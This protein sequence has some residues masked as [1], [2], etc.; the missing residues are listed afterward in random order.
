MFRLTLLSVAL[1]M[2]FCCKS[3]EKRQILSKKHH[4]QGKKGL[5]AAGNMGSSDA[6]AE[7]LR[8]G[9]NA[10]DAA[11]ATILALSITDN[12]DFCIGS[13]AAFLYYDAKSGQVTAF[14]GQGTAPLDPEAIR[15]Y[16]EHGI[17][18]SS[19]RAAAVPAVIDL[20]V[21][22][23]RKC[24]TL[25]FREV[26]RPAMRMLGGKEQDWYPD[27]LRTFRRLE[28]SERKAR[29]SRE[30]KL[31]AV[32]DCFYRGE[33]ADSLVAWYKRTGAFLTREDLA[34][35]HTRVEK[36]VS[37]PFAGYEVYKCGP[38][39]QG[40]VLLEELR[41]L[42]G[43]DLSMFDPGSA[44]YVHLVTEAMKLGLADR[45]TYYGDPLFA[46]VP[47]KNLISES[48]S[49]LRRPL[50]SMEE[51][52]A[53][54]RPGDPFK[55]KALADTAYYLPVSHGTTTCCI[56]DKWG[57]AVAATPS[58]WGSEAGNGGSTGVKHG[59]RLIS[60]NTTPGHPNAIEAGKRPRT[61]LTPTLVLKNGKPVLALSIEGGDVQDQAALQL[62]LDVLIYGMSPEQALAGPRFSTNLHQDS[63]N[64]DKDRDKAYP[65]RANSFPESRLFKGNARFTGEN[66][67]RDRN[68]PGQRRNTGHDKIRSGHRHGLF[69][70]SARAAPLHKGC[71]IT[72]PCVQTMKNNP[73][74]SDLK[75]SR[76]MLMVT[77]ST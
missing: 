57:N 8:S 35:Y 17:P 72:H 12:K 38:W 60:F 9:G 55:M 51:A 23:L 45:D 25:S 20:C 44:A 61:T 74:T 33:I 48:Y 73:F 71:R 27:L 41:L 53:A 58:G 49:S 5:V 26:A 46:K 4:D 13:E 70:H 15:W 24:G 69:S 42:E 64:P 14:S 75:P 59:T 68:L 37:V 67:S 39:C 43:W 66:G 54:C 77:G 3:P 62:L 21:T 34:N 10:A 63:F 36:P 7:I 29:G 28:K 1:L 52:S 22:V 18:Q 31:Q 56:V 32:A 47:V 16:D 50:I 6:G 2:L 40:P 30:D 65:G 76:S 19:I 11:V